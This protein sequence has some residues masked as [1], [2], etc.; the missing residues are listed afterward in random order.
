MKALFS[1]AAI[2][3]STLS[4]LAGAIPGTVEP[5]SQDPYNTERIEENVPVAERLPVMNARGELVGV[6]HQS[7]PA[8]ELHALYLCGANSGY[9]YVRGNIKDE[10]I[11]AIYNDEYD[12]ELNVEVLPNLLRIK[13]SIVF[14]G[15]A[16]DA[17]YGPLQTE[18][19]VKRP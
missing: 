13:M 10:S 15:E 19:Y 17:D 7:L 9:Y 11:Y 4:A 18:L 5:C 14:S 6:F 12:S 1:F 2:T 3:L 8:G 16:E